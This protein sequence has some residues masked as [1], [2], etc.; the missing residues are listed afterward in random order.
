[1][2]LAF[3]QPDLVCIAEVSIGERKKVSQEWI[4]WRP[5]NAFL[6]AFFVLVLFI[7]IF[8]CSFPLVF[9]ASEAP[10]FCCLC[11]FC[12]SCPIFNRSCSSEVN[13][14][15]STKTL[16]VWYRAMY[17][18]M[19]HINI[20]G[21]ISMRCEWGVRFALPIANLVLYTKYKKKNELHPIFRCHRPIS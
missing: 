15:F 20:Y 16:P 21:K 6:K 3:W 12:S 2:S 1:M 17:F 4:T 13:A 5:F 11:P 18:F 14:H 9:L 8:H 7:S 19:T 10:C